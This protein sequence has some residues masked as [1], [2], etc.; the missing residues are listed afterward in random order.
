MKF[1]NR[2][3]PKLLNEN[4]QA[5]AEEPTPAERK[6]VNERAKEHFKRKQEFEKDRVGFYKTLSKVGFGVGG[7]GALIGL[8]GVVAVAG[9][10]PLKTSEPYVIRVD[11]NTGFTDIVKPISDSLQTT[12]GEELDKYWLSKFIIERESYDW[13]LVQNSYDA[14][15]LMTTPQVFNEYKA[16]IT[17]KVSPVNLLQQNKK[18][19]VR[20]LSVAFINGVGQV[21][22]SKQVLTASGE[23]DSVIPVTYWVASIP[24]DYKHDIKLEQQRLI[25]PLGFQA[26]SYRADPENL[27]NK[28]EQK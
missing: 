5:L 26:L 7:V 9:L 17:S 14:V 21:R 28:D 15:E 13:Q 4:V 12:Y 23:P 10:T 24:F 1:F 20:V 16:Y 27:I 2:S 25:N 22:F 11:N 19:K 18:I 3:K 8:A 6:I